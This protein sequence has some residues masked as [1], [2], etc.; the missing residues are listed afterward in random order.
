V[1][2]QEMG[3]PTGH[4]SYTD[5]SVITCGDNH[6]LGRI[7]RDGSNGLTVGRE[8]GLVSVEIELDEPPSPPGMS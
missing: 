4:R 8:K 7:Q 3:L 1:A 6:T 2:E 5:N